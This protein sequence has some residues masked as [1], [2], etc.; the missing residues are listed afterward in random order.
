MLT[1]RTPVV[2][3]RPAGHPGGWPS[4]GGRTGPP[5]RL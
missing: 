2:R 4:A 1:C 3:G 5:R